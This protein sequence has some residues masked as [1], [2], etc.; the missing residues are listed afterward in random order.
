MNHKGR[1]SRT[2]IRP[3]F[4]P[5]LA[6]SI[7]DD[8]SDVELSA[9]S[10]NDA[11][12]WNGSIWTNAPA[13]GGGAVA[14]DDLTDVVITAANTG[15]YL[16]YSGTNW[17]DVTV[18]QLL[19]DL[20]TVD[21]TGSGLDA[22]LLDGNHASAFA[23]TA[24]THT[25]NDLSDVVITSAAA[26]DY[27]RHN[28][29]DWVDSPISQMLTDI[30]TV[31]GTGSGLDADLLDGNEASAFAVVAHTH[32]VDDLS[33]V[34]ITAAAAGDYL[35]YNGSAWVDVDATQLLTDIKTVDGT[36]SGL[37]ADTLDGNDASAFA[38]SGHTHTL[39]DLSDV[40][41]TAAATGDYV[42]HNGSAWVD[43]G[44][45]QVVTDL[46]AVLPRVVTMADAAS[47]APN[48]DTSDI[49]EQSNT[50][51]AGTL[52][53]NAPTGTPIDGQKLILR[54]KSTNGQTYSWNGIYRG[55]STIT[56]PTTHAG[57]GVTDYIGLIYNNTAV[58]WD[59]IAVAQGH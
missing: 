29:S 48:A 32:T 51:V 22:D 10:V 34:T 27:I 53:A 47:F 9:L 20:S 55:G 6:H 13:G 30:K 14:L 52:T 33:D 1:Q 44:V 17:V 39:N 28:G 15:D 40:T 54:I 37:D 26:G 50:Q 4:V 45:S 18:S 16:R 49:A 42:R 41:I 12:I 5:L 36:G 56:L 7:I 24:H 2:R 19:T 46:K 8:L 23:L 57:G 3:K 43:V 35:R 31:D 59:C 25:I 38:T 58:K 21:G 11:L